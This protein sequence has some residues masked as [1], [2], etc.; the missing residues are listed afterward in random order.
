MLALKYVSSPSLM[1]ASSVFVFV[2][3]LLSLNQCSPP[4]VLPGAGDLSESQALGF[5]VEQLPAECGD[6]Q[7]PADCRCLTEATHGVSPLGPFLR[8]SKKESFPILSFVPSCNGS[9]KMSLTQRA[10]P[11]NTAAGGR[12]VKDLVSSCSCAEH[13]PGWTEAAT[14]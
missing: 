12:D 5:R 2:T 6:G 7:D 14:S 4:W 13:I 10:L 3:C 11:G 9:L 8:A 1:A